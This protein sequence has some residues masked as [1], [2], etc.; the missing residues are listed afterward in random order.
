VIRSR[1]RWARHE[2]CI[3]VVT[4]PYKIIVGKIERQKQLG[5]LRCIW[6]INIKTLLKGIGSGLGSSDQNRFQWWTLVNTV[7]KFRDT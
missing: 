7:T 6:E 5:R 3:G 4:I 1:R 2:E